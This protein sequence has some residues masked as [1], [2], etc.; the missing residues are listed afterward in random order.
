MVRVAPWVL[1]LAACAYDAPPL[2]IGDAGPPDAAPTLDG[3][4]ASPGCAV[5]SDCASGVCEAEACVPSDQV[6]YVATNGRDTR[7][8]TQAEP[9]ATVARAVAQSPSEVAVVAVSS[10][11]YREAIEVNPPGQ[12]RID[13]RIIGRTGSEEPVVLQLPEQSSAPALVQILGGS[14]YL[15]NVRLVGAATAAH[16]VLAQAGT[17]AEFDGVTVTGHGGA[18]IRC[19]GCE[20][21]LS[22]VDVT[23]NRGLGV[24]VTGT[25]VD[26]GAVSL[27][28]SQVR[29]NAAGGVSAEALDC[30]VA[31]SVLA[32]NGNPMAAVGG[33]ALRCERVRFE[34]NTV[35]GNVSIAAASAY[36]CVSEDAINRNNLYASASSTV[37]GCVHRYSH[38]TAGA[39]PVG[40]GNRLAT[41][42]FVG[43][44]NYHL[45]PDAPARG[46]AEPGAQAEIPFDLDGEPRV[47]GA[48]DVGADEIP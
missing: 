42:R 21:V 38:W 1:L 46:V 27:F 31:S 34:H 25:A 7:P 12:A 41:P 40:E 23:G 10:G 13:V 22:G 24:S 17:T 47:Q 18:G 29:S 28:R 39:V 5:D 48:P 44:G 8:C 16:G 11:I 43:A 36:A 9:C 20:L 33:A 32:D 26:G 37:V 6:R 14:G 19:E 30:T 2:V 35:A 45:S 3:P 15:R 4:D